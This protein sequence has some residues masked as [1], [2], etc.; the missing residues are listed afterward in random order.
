[1]MAVLECFGY[2]S[3]TTFADVEPNL[4]RRGIGIS[5]HWRLAARLASVFDYVNTFYHRFPL[6]DVTRPPEDLFGQLDFVICSDVLEHI[7]PPSLDGLKGIRRM[8]RDGG[9]AVITVPCHTGPTTS[10]YYPGL[11]SWAIE[12][13]S[14]SWTDGEGVERIDSNPEFHGG[15]GQTLAFRMWSMD[16]LIAKCVEA[17]FSQVVFPRAWPPFD[18]EQFSLDAAGF[19]IAWA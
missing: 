16:D 17:G 7:P 4:A 19:V 3:S 2:P 10:E 11:K 5:D 12:D 15:Q 9:Y 14:V 13:G 18:P 8:L 6:V 1:M